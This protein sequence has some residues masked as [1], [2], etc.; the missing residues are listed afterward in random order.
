MQVR[1]IKVYRSPKVI[2]WDLQIPKYTVHILAEFDKGAYRYFLSSTFQ[3]LP[4]VCNLWTFNI[5]TDRDYKGAKVFQE[6]YAL[7]FHKIVS[8]YSVCEKS[9][10]Q[11]LVKLQKCN[12]ISDFLWP[13]CGLV[14]F[15]SSLLLYRNIC[16][17]IQVW[18]VCNDRIQLG[19][20]YHLFCAKSPRY[21]KSVSYIVYYT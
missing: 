21:F 5:L 20:E 12:T 9:I 18:H 17:Y 16:M 7:R 15:A 8:Q 10:W 4:I 2:L 14:I 11:H 13:C 3:A 1:M 19:K 6:S